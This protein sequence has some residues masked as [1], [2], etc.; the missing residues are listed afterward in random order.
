M[1]SD[2]PAA[3]EA[4][5]PEGTPDAGRLSRLGRGRLLL[6]ALPI[7][8]IVAVT[9]FIG[10][11]AL[12]AA[13]PLTAHV[14]VL[15]GSMRTVGAS[16]SGADEFGFIH[17]GTTYRILDRSTSAVL[18]S[19][20]LPDGVAARLMSQDP[21]S[22]VEPTA[23]TMSWPIRLPLVDTYSLVLGDNRPIPF[24][25][26]AIDTQKSEL[27]VTITDNS[28]GS[29]PTVPSRAVGAMQPGPSGSAA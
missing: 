6:I 9:A 26:S 24:D 5:A 18:V 14:V 10:Y 22:K 27:T 2:E 21:G 23:C 1:S 20:T 7:A 13:T 12:F 19:G 11:G 16:C 3:V 29:R 17:L 15:D 28:L 25:R 4:T 8:V